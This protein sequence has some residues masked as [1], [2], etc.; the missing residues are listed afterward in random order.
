MAWGSLWSAAHDAAGRSRLSGGR[1]GLAEGERRALVLVADDRQQL[2]A[3]PGAPL[4]RDLRAAGSSV[5]P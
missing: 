3:A 5:R 2:H 1:I 4:S